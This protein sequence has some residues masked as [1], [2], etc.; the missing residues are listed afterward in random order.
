MAEMTPKEKLTM[1][2]KAAIY[3]QIAVKEEAEDNIRRGN[4]QL[5]L[6]AS[7]PERGEG[8]PPPLDPKSQ[9]VPSTEEGTEGKTQTEEQ[10]TQENA[11]TE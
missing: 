4:E 10:A 8:V 5:R 1:Q 6:I 9:G 2:I 3:D 7:Q 11:P